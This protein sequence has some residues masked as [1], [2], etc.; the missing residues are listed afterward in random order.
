MT[1]VATARHG[2]VDASVARL[3]DWLETGEVQAG[4]LADDCFLDLSL[5]HWRIQVEGVADCLAV[6][7]EQHPFP[8][9]VRVERVDRT[10]GGFVMAFE[11]RWV[12]EGQTWYCREQFAA[13]VDPRGAITDLRVYC[14]GD[15]DEARQ[16][17][18]AAE[19]KLIRP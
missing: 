18:H 12:A 13:D 1:S 7:R 8:G 5:P 9:A 14:T 17:E 4:M 16:A 6:R 11:E 19:V 2:E 10:E 15:W 3:V